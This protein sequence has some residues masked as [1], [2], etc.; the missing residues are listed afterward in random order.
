MSNE[1]KMSSLLREIRTKLQK[2]GIISLI[3][4]VPSYLYSSYL[5]PQLALREEIVRYSGI[6]SPYKVSVIDRI[7]PGYSRPNDDPDYELS[8]VEAVQEFSMRGDKVVIVGAGRGITSTVAAYSVEEDGQVISYEGSVERLS[9]AKK[10]IQHNKVDDIVELHHKIVG[11][12]KK[13][14]GDIGDASILPPSE[15][16]SCDYLELDCEGAEELVLKDMTIK[17]RV[18]SVETHESM[19]VSHSNVLKLLDDRGYQI[20]KETDKTDQYE[21]IRHVVAKTSV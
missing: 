15:L 7:V 10:T 14:S 21:G 20:I 2:D 8:E 1:R 4:S 3:T 17:P 9:R 13:V 5:L 18:I 19:D 6:E 12:N 11:E 16:P